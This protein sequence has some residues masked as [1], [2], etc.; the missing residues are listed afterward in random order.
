MPP[1][2]GYARGAAGWARAYFLLGGLGALALG[3]LL[4]HH[5]RGIACWLGIAFALAGL[6]S[7][8]FAVAAKRQA[9]GQAAC[10][11]LDEVAPLPA[12]SDAPGPHPLEPPHRPFDHRAH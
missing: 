8:L 6:G 9:V 2:P 3:G 5:E 10:G 12:L 11:S 1:H 4:A 7:M